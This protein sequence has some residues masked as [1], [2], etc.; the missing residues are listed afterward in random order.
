MK[1]ETFRK[2]RIVPL[3]AALLIPLLVGGFS[4]LLTAEDMNIYETM[5]RP[6]LAPPGWVFPI[7]WTILYVLMGL[8]SYFVYTSDVEPERK[9]KALLYYAA[10]LAMNL[11]WSTLFFTYA[12][13]LLSLIWLLVMW[14]LILI[15]TIRFY[16]I[17][18]SA[19]L[20]MG[21]LFLWTTFA[22][23]LNLACYVMSITPMPLIN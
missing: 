10:Q 4:A 22:A 17:R 15:C 7:V 14:G 8:A 1:E 9:R 6:L 13:Y 18:R 20:M 5:N 23:Y 11:F 19:G 3:I 21:G 16:R 12:R 2:L